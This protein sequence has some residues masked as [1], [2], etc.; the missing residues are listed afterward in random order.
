M[1]KCGC[2]KKNDLRLPLPPLLI[3]SPES[4]YSALS[5]HTR[6]CDDCYVLGFGKELAEFRHI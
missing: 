3:F 4:W 1:Y 2:V 5:T 6:S